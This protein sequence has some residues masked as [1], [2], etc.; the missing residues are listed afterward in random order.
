MWCLVN[1]TVVNCRKPGGPCFLCCKFRGHSQKCCVV[2]G[3]AGSREL[4]HM[5]H[6][7]CREDPSAG[8]GSRELS[9]M[10]HSQCRE[11][12][13]AGLRGYVC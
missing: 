9:H 5:C 2:R 7:Q 8:A 3:F 11:D 10:C 1:S 13:S 6:S 4:S 12:P